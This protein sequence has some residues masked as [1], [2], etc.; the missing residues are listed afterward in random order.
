[1]LSLAAALT[2]S[3]VVAQT[4]DP[5]VSSSLPNSK[6][7]MGAVIAPAALPSGASAAY[8][9]LGIQEIGAGYRQGTGGVEFEARATF[10][11]LLL[12][13]GAEVAAKYAAF[14]S[15]RIEVAPVL[16]FGLGLDTGARYFDKANFSYFALRP[17]IGAVS[18][19]KVTDTLVA[20][21]TIDV[22]WAFS[23]NPTGG[24][25]TRPMAGGGVEV[26]LGSDMTALVLG[27]LGVDAIKEPLGVT[28]VR[29][30]YQL[31]LG[32]GFRL[33]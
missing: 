20:L 33:F 17:R 10:N 26:Y 8:G 31:M 4:N 30:G 2:F 18:T 11:Y 21:A 28:Q 7:V 22:P 16:G 24:T 27:Q 15:D 23:V 5:N 29:L 1:M 12:S 14:R 13:A 6:E 19:F 3:A 32:L 9:F 25:H